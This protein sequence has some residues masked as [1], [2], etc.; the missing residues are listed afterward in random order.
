VLDYRGVVEQ[1]D[2][3]APR[4]KR[5]ELVERQRADLFVGD[6]YLAVCVSELSQP[7]AVSPL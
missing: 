4:G 3:A 7:I 6:L 5:S 1:T 2:A